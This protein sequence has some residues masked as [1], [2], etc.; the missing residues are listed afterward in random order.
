MR[1]LIF[2]LFTFHFSLFTGIA[3]SNASLYAESEY[4]NLPS[5]SD[6][7]LAEQVLAK[8]NAYE[9]AKPALNAVTKRNQTLMLKDIK[10]FKEVNSE[11]FTSKQNANVADR[12][13][14]LKVNKGVSANSIFLCQSNSNG[15]SK[16]LYLLVYWDEYRPKVEIINYAPEKDFYID[17]K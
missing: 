17:F 16:N 4:Y 7:R 9:A 14:T 6:K 2:S 12:L 11:N 1:L 10:S 8:I 3:F 5:C 13:I 15:P